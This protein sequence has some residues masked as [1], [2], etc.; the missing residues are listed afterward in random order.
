M[1]FGYFFY[2]LCWWYS[3]GELPKRWIRTMGID[4][5]NDRFLFKRIE[6]I[7]F[8][9]QLCTIMELWHRLSN[10][11]IKTMFFSR[12]R[13]N[14]EIYDFEVNLYCILFK[15]HLID[16]MALNVSTRSDKRVQLNN[17][18]AQIW[19]QTITC[20]NNDPWTRSNSNTFKSR[21]P[22]CDYIN[23]RMDL[24]LLTNSGLDKMAVNWPTVL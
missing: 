14:N 16:F 4:K 15:C 19:F 5:C 13:Y 11:T 18:L 17:E 20:N 24:R 9:H 23:V 1:L 22:K 6:V 2:N 8:R 3:H 10:N 12:Y 7:K 21:I